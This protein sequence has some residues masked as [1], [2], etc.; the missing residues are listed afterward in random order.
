MTATQE[1]SEDVFAIHEA[2]A[3]TEH[4]EILANKIRYE[5][6]NLAQL[7]N[8]EWIG[9]LGADVNNLT[10][11]PLTYGLAKSFI[12][13]TERE[14]AVY[15]NEADQLLLKVAAIIHDQGESIVG[16]ISFGDK[17]EDDEAEE[18]LQFEQ[19][20]ESFCPGATI[21]MKKLIVRA[22]DE[23]VFDS[24]TKV[25]KVFNAI[26]RVGYIRTAL[27]ASTHVQNETA[28]NAEPGLR[29]II[30]DVFSN[31]PVKLIEYAGEYPAVRNYL[32][33]QRDKITAA[34]GVVKPE[35]FENYGANQRV[36]ETQFQEAYI[37]W[38]GW[39]L[40]STSVAA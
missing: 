29:W 23:V 15:L 18:K 21:E 7:A 16:D 8:E 34:F 35:D 9:L 20:L 22:R 1:L 11:M 38:Q 12:R 39:L 6:Y 36:K 14:G 13:E 24:T 5:K 10:H 26:E 37:A 30:A 33:H 4:G 31:Q 2:F 32:L 27:R 25:G 17:T 28:G 3:A 19:N 40:G